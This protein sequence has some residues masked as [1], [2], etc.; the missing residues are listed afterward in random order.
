MPLPTTEFDALFRQICNICPLDDVA[1]L[2]CD[3]IT[4]FS[5]QAI[6]DVFGGLLGLWSISSSMGAVLPVIHAMTMTPSLGSE[7][8]PSPLIAFPALRTIA[9]VHVTFQQDAPDAIDVDYMQQQL[10]ER[11]ERGFEVQELRLYDCFRLRGE[12]VKVLREIVVDVTWD[13]CETGFSDEEEESSYDG[14]HMDYG[15]GDL[16]YDPDG[17][18]FMP[19]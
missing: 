2:S 13:G 19:F 5:P 16:F 7:T 8:E 14:D 3:S 1:E 18:Y 4:D 6:V 15:D 10:I 17:D 9:L 12:D 11:Y